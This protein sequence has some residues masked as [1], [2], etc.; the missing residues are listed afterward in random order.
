MTDTKPLVVNRAQLRKDWL[1][2]NEEAAHHR[3]VA[4]HCFEGSEQQRRARRLAEGAE[5]TAQVLRAVAEAPE[6]DAPVNDV[7]CNRTTGEP[8]SGTVLIIP[9]TIS[10]DEGEDI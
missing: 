6:T 1:H 7:V 8:I 2:Y 10:P 3:A 9:A 4:H 5:R